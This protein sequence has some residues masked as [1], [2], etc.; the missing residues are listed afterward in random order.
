M[1]GIQVI[2]NYDRIFARLIGVSAS[3]HP[4]APVHGIDGQSAVAVL[5]LGII[6]NAIGAVNT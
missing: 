3:P 4:S 5:K 2:S 6:R 1:A